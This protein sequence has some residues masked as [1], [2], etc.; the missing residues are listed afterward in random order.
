MSVKSL[1]VVCLT[2][3][4]LATPPPSKAEEPCCSVTAIDTR[5]QL[6]TAKETKTGRTFQFKVSDARLLASIKV[7]QA[8]QADFTTMKVS[9]QPSGIQPCCAIVN[10]T[11][12]APTPGR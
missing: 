1:L 12:P 3:A 2:L 8:I 9:A 7:G 6:V 11:P 10:L 5:A 4:A